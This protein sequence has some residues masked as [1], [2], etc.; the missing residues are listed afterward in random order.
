MDL[1]IFGQESLQVFLAQVLYLYLR[2]RNAHRAVMVLQIFRKQSKNSV[3]HFL[4]KNPFSE[5]IPG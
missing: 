3:L 5:S 1:T 2:T 4:G